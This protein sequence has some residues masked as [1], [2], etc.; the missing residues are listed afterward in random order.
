MTDLFPHADEGRAPADH[1]ER[2]R[3]MVVTARF[4]TMLVSGLATFALLATML[5]LPVPYAVQ[6][7][8]P[9]FNTLAGHE[10]EQADDDE[11]SETGASPGSGSSDG[12]VG[13]PV[14][15]ADGELRLITISGSQVYPAAGELRL[16][17]VVTAG[18]PG[19]PV[20]AGN[21]ILAYW[22]R[23]QAV[24]PVEAAFDPSLTREERDELSAQQMITSQ[25]HAT[26]AALTELGYEVPAVMHI[27]DA[28]PGTGAEGVVQEG[29]LITGIRGT[30]SEDVTDVTTYADLAEV[31]QATAAGEEVTLVVER[32]GQEEPLPIITTDDGLGNTQLGIFLQADFDM[33]IEV[34]IAIENVGG[35]S[36][37]VMFAL[38]IIDVLTPGNL[39]GGNNIAGTGTISLDGR[40]GPIG[41][42]DLKMIG[43][44]ED[45]AE[46]FLAPTANCP[47]VVEN[48][49][50]GLEV[51]AVDHL[52]QARVAVEAIADGDTGDL[53]ECPAVV[54]EV[55]VD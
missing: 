7:P 22:D 51:V 36:A 11:S 15:G 12:D 8:G 26:V 46:Y 41:G 30:G 10:P 21:V 6:G 4:V 29:D 48:I 55:Q 16:T 44:V 23:E 45:G 32:D 24:Q 35:P 39:T 25:E 37:G 27:V 53:P 42:V 20:R 43:A 34:E 14:E 33:P 17:T 47:E 1:E 5:V 9:T 2:P 3:K 18:G 28:A 52:S 40:V 50:D 54:D 31:L 13:E 49:P 38:G 19:Y